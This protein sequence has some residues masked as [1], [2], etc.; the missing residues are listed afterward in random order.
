MV[1]KVLFFRDESG[2]SPVESYIEKLPESQQ[3]KVFAYIR[4][5]EEVGY[6]LKRP[7]GDYL[8]DK[9]G[10]YELRPGR[11]RF[12]YYFHARKYIVLLHA[13]L[14]RT[15]EIPVSEIRIA[16]HQKEICESMFKNNTVDLND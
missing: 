14:K 4:R 15:E 5:L 7:A 11:H 16:L 9:T 13:F 10:L 2:E 1:F 3:N 12:L 8:G 6:A